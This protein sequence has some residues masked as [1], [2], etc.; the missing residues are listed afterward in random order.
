MDNCQE[1]PQQSYTETISPGALHDVENIKPTSSELNHLWITYMAESMS[2]A[3]LK[4]M[5]AKSND[6]LFHG[7]LAFALETSSQNVIA[8]ESVFERIRHPIPGGFGERDVDINAPELFADEFSMRYTKLMQKYIVINHSIA[9]SDCSRPDIKNMFS[10]FMDKARQVID[11]LDRALLA[12]GLFAKSPY[13]EIPEQVEY[14]HDKDYYGSFWGKSD[15]PLNVVEISNI[16][17]IMDFKMAMKALKLGFSQV[18]KSRMVRHHLVRG[19]EMADKQLEVLGMLMENDGLPKPEIISDRVTSSTQ[20]PYSDR[21]MMFHSSIAMGR[22]ILAYGMGMTN[23]V[24]KDILT[25]F[26]RLTIEILEFSKSGVDIMIKNGWLERVP[27]AAD[28]RKLV[29]VKH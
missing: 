6:P 22:I 8:L 19:I 5:V 24:R 20:S 25:H 14:V 21:L 7:A 15:R 11:K 13:V 29:R 16:Y 1:T 17:N 4:H 27:E 12:K 3:M 26:S 23:S 18:A 2:I 9:F 10:E 28:R